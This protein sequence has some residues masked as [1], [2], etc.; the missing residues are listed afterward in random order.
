MR[1][2]LFRAKKKEDGKWMLGFPIRVFEYGG[3]VWTMCPFNTMFEVEEPVIPKTIGQYT[4]LKDKNGKMIFEG[5]IV[6]TDIKRPYNIV[7]F[8]DGC[9]MFNCND[10]DDD[11]YDIMLPILK[12]PH[13]VYEYGEVIGNIYDNPELI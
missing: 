5:D 7:E 12:E 3:D 10:G 2:I 6:S 1:E 13:T 8:R 4:G 11:Y 9:F